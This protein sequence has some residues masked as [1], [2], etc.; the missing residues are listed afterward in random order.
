MQ[1]KIFLKAY[2]VK[3]YCMQSPSFRL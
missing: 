2:Q 1:L 3:V